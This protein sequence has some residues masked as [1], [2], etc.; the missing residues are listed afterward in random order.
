MPA[1]VQCGLPNLTGALCYRIALVQALFHIPQVVNCL[2]DY[3][4]P[5]HCLADDRNDCFA[6]RF[7][8][9]AKAYW[10]KIPLQALF[11]T[12]HVL[13]RRRGWTQ[14]GQADPGEQM[15]FFLKLLREDLPTS[16]FSMVDST[17]K[18]FT[19]QSIP[20]TCGHSSIST[21]TQT[22]MSVALA[23]QLQNGELIRYI[24]RGLRDI[25]DYRCEKCKSLKKRQL[26][27][28]F[29]HLPEILC[30]QFNQQDIYG[31]KLRSNIKLPL[32]FDLTRCKTSESTD[33]DRIQYHLISIVQH[34][35]SDNMGHYI[36]TAEGPDGVWKNF[37][38]TQVH[39]SAPG[40]V[41]RSFAPVLCF[42]RRI[43][44]APQSQP[45]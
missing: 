20:C 2:W 19:K 34:S 3:H 44:E 5:D 10:M 22:Q 23:P 8:S 45:A 31:R 7:R 32:A 41:N 27:R 36:C 35:G 9:L 24:D 26:T 13:L 21:D 28:K 17:F 12:L 30:C 37:N 16:V 6:C 40:A 43:R 29:E 14:D 15:L 4:L 39:G 25:I 11:K 42:F 18:A 1:A 38:D 33:P